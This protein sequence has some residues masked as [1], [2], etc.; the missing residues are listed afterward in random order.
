M[1]YERVILGCF[2]RYS[3][4]N[5]LKT[6]VTILKCQILWFLFVNIFIRLYS[7]QHY[8]VLEQFH[9]LKKQP[10]NHLYSLPNFALPSG[11]DSYN[12]LA[13]SM[14]LPFLVTWQKWSHTVFMLLFLA[15][16]SNVICMKYAH[17]VGIIVHFYLYVIF[18]HMKIL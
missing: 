11:P 1:W 16:L 13:A 2:L 4:Q 14:D 5:F 8:P 15:S 3:S 9:Y 12:L 7:Y 10:C 6:K 17:V 18:Y